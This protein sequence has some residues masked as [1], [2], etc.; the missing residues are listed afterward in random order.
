MG[1]STRYQ[2]T[3]IPEVDP[4][5]RATE[6]HEELLPYD[7]DQAVLE[8]RRCLQCAMPFCV[9]ACPITQDCRGYIRLIG[10]ERFD[11]AARLTLQDNPLATV[12]C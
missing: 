12:L 8:A 4:K 2:R 5:E 10:E 9:Q 7:R 11:D 1:E 3:P 6:F